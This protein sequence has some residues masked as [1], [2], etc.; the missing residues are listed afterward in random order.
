MPRYACGKM[1]FEKLQ[2]LKHCIGEK[3][4]F[5]LYAENSPIFNCFLIWKE[6]SDIPGFRTPDLF[7]LETVLILL[8]DHFFL[9]LAFGSS[10]TLSSQQVFPFSMLTLHS[11][12]VTGYNYNMCF[13]SCFLVK[14]NEKNPRLYGCR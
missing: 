9:N 12:G 6:V 14:K 1:C 11:Y 4:S 7:L 3:M 8:C 10:Y 13:F 2:Y 5:L